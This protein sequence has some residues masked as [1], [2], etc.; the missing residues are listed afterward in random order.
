VEDA[1]TY[2]CG[3]DLLVY[4]LSAEAEGEDGEESTGQEPW[5]CVTDQMMSPLRE[6]IL[7]RR[8]RE[9]DERAFGEFVKA[10]K[11][12]VFNLLF[13]MLS[14]REE[15]EDVAQEVFITVFKNIETFR[16]D[17]R[18]STWIYRIATNHCRNRIKYLSRRKMQ[19]H[20]EYQD[21]LAKLQPREGVAGQPTAGQ[22]ARPDQMAEGREMEVLV[23]EA[24]AALDD[25]HREIIVLRDIQN[26]P[27]QE[28]CE[29]TGLPPGTVKSRL[30]R[31]R[32]ALKEKL[33]DV[34]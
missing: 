23:Q 20:R 4:N 11:N 31:A 2:G 18:L 3:D 17:C 21:E 14:N 19:D 12:Q 32:L 29:I 5:L 13:R 27:Y 6:K 34:L 30:H 1:E 8:L 9:H 28:I 26:L 7:V 10:Y 16:G 33:K 15:A 25:D 24:I 22:V